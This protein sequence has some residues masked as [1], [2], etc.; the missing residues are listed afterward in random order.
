MTLEEFFSILS[1]L[2]LAQLIKEAKDVN[3][4]ETANAALVELGKRER[5]RGGKD[6]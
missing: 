2:E 4:T 1:D 3:D 5:N 6:E